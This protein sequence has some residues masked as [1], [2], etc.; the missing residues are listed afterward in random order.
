M[1]KRVK[2]T[3]NV[4]LLQRCKVFQKDIRSEVYVSKKNKI[5]AEANL[6]PSNL[7][8]AV[9]I[10]LNKSNPTMPNITTENNVEI[11]TDKRKASAFAEFF[12]NKVKKFQI[13]QL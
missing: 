4:Q 3:G 2:K 11:Q 7:W 1:H 13:I 10:A 5:R 8:K 9:N 6:G 12:E